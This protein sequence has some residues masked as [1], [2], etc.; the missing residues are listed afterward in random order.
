MKDWK[1]FF[2]YEYA[3]RSDEFSSLEEAEEILWKEFNEKRA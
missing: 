1:E 3:K 2:D